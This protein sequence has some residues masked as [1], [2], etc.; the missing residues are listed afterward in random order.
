MEKLNIVLEKMPEGC[1]DKYGLELL[2]SKYYYWGDE[3]D[4]IPSDIPMTIDDS[5]HK[6]QEREMAL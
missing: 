2:L 3:E 1:L 6:D 4:R 5:Y